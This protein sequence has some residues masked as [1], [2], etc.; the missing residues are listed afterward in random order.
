MGTA[1]GRAFSGLRASNDLSVLR[2]TVLWHYSV[3]GLRLR[4]DL[5]IPGLSASR[6]AEDADV[7]V[8]F[9]CVPRWLRQEVEEAKEKW[10][11]LNRG[12]DGKPTL[13]IKQTEDG[14]Y[15]LFVYSEGV[16]FIVDVEG[17]RVWACW[18][19]KLNLGD[20]LYYL[21]GPIL[22]LVL[23]L[24]GITSLH[25][26]GFSIQGQAIAIMGPGGSGKSTLAAVFG[27][28]GYPVLTDDIL[29]LRD[30]IDSFRVQPGYPNLLLW[31]ESVNALYGS[32]EALPYI[33]PGWEKRY[34]D[35]IA[36]GHAF[37]REPLPLA[38]I[39]VLGERSPNPEAPVIEALQGSNSLMALLLN[40]YGLYLTD[41]SMRA[42]D[43]ELLG[44]VAAYVPIRR[45]TPHAE[46]S[47]VAGLCD[48]I[49][50]DAAALIP[51][52]VTKEN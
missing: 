19:D 33:T 2:Y 17:T 41:R 40:T 15:L 18:Q 50:E 20:V 34:L 30:E 47:R 46:A 1:V 16:E 11:G 10:C 6:E 35:T 29:A 5:P 52:L 22:G 27:R 24:R 32:K 42:R 38:A 31:P 13:Q 43:F 21:R 4:T 39:Y 37:A 23:R 12:E 9:Q 26:S 14:Q 8:R 49:L 28:R 44:R 25:A 3:Y 51:S 36:E 7:E 45:V 48:R